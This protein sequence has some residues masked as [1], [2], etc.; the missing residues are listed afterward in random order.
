MGTRSRRRRSRDRR[1]PR[2]RRRA[3]R[4]RGRALAQR[5]LGPAR[6]GWRQRR[7][8]R[9]ARARRRRARARLA[10]DVFCHRARKY[11]GA[12]LAVLGGADAVVFTGGVGE[13]APEIRRRIAAGLDWCGLALDDGR[14]AA[15]TRRGRRDQPPTGS[16]IRALVIAADEERMIAHE[17]ARLP[18]ARPG[19]RGG[20]HPMNREPRSHDRHRAAA[21]GV[22]RRLRGHPSRPLTRRAGRRAG[23][24]RSASAARAATGRRLWE[25]L[26]AADRVASAGDVAGRPRDLRR[27]ACT[28]TA[29]RSRPTTSRRSPRATPAA[30]STWCRPTSATWPPT[31]SPGSRAPGS[32]ARATASPRSTRVNLLVGN[33]TRRPT[34]RATTLSD[35]GLT[36]YVRDFYSLPA[37]RRTAGRS[38]RSAATSTP[39]PPAASPRAAISASP[40]CST[41]TCRCRASGWWRSSPTAPSRSSAAATGRRAGGAP[42]TR[43]LVAPIMIA[44]GRRIDQRTTMSQQGGVDVVRAPPAAQRLRSRSCSTGAIPAAFAWAILRDRA[45]ARRRRRTR[46][47]EGAAALPGAACPTAIAVA[48]KGAGFPGAGTNLAHNLPLGGNPRTDAAARAALQRAAPRGCGCRRTSCAAA[49]RRACS[50]TTRRGA[51]ASATTAL[52]AATVPRRACPRRPAR[53]VPADRADRR[54]GRAASPMAAVDDGFLAHR[55][56]QSPAAPARR[57]PR[58]DALEPD[59]ARRSSALKFRVT[60]PE[61]GIPEAVDGAV[62]TALNEEAVAC[63]ALANKGGIN[64]VVTYE[65]FGAKMHGAVRQ[66]IIF[67]EHLG[68]GRPAAG[69]AVGP[70]G[71]HLAHLGERQER[72][73]APGPGD[74]RGDAGRGLATSRACCSRPTPTRAAAVVDGGVRTRGQIWTLVVPKGDAHPRSLHRRRGAR[75]GRATAPLAL[76]GRAHD[77]SGPG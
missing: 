24:R 22:D 68:R 13:R 64:L 3:S 53:P 27:A 60:A 11:L 66:E 77:P 30:R 1:L 35:A 14:N 50:T 26:H 42:R 9:S 49:R 40:S 25:L 23:R 6:A 12:Y 45:A 52:A 73:V 2:P 38:R 67:A 65:A 39:T 8:A 71:A 7:H 36:R 59:A 32:W 61:A 28:S 16:A 56:G 43:G 18:G 20:D 57:Q 62:I 10:V 33:L 76:P 51:R 44:N 34:P 19:A 21:A 72:A 55:A 54:R 69:L 47:R 5:A 70:A 15:A 74:G 37:R 63:A 46:S 58:R 4:G 17:T 31:R 29:A 41:C 75:A 48:P